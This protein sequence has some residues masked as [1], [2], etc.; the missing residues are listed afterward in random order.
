LVG[1]LDKTLPPKPQ[2]NNELRKQ[3]ARVLLFNIGYDIERYL[4]KEAHKRIVTIFP[5]SNF[6]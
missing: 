3:E 5:I 1:W 2:N 6:S 4:V